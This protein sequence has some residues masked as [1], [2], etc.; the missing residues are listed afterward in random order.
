M[1]AKQKS[2]KTQKASTSKDPT[3]EV[4]VPIF[5]IVAMSPVRPRKILGANTFEEAKQK[6]VDLKTK[7]KFTLVYIYEAEGVYTEF[8]NNIQPVS[9][10][11]QEERE[12][13]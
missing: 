11:I 10:T 13:K 6:V 3:W 7:D 4:Y 12:K 1:S 9:E 8:F 2:T 5:L